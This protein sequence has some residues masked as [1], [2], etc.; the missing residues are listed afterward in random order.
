MKIE[1]TITT[2]EKVTL[3][4]PDYFRLE[5]DFHITSLCK[6]V[7]GSIMIIK[8][9]IIVWDTEL[10]NYQIENIERGTITE[11]TAD[12]FYSELNNLIDELK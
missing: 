4:L 8:K 12:E 11:I 7:E 5:A 3:T 9:G 1:A 2:R 6:V 10:S